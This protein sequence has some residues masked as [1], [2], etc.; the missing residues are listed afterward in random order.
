MALSKQY[1]RHTPAVKEY[2]L[3]LDILQHVLPYL[4]PSTL[5]IASLSCK[6]IR[7][8]AVK[9]LERSKKLV[10]VLETPR[11]YFLEERSF[12]EIL[13]I[14]LTELRRM[15]L[16]LDMDPTQSSS[17]LNE[18]IPTDDE[19]VA[20]M[21]H[22]HHLETVL[23]W[24]VENDVPSPSV[25]SPERVLTAKDY[26]RE[27]GIDMMNRKNNPTVV[28]VHKPRRMDV[29]DFGLVIGKLVDILNQFLDVQFLIELPN[30]RISWP[31]SQSRGWTEPGSGPIF[32][33]MDNSSYYARGGH[34]F[35]MTEKEFYDATGI[36]SAFS[37]STKSLRG[38][39]GF[40][41]FGVA[42]NGKQ[43]KRISRKGNY[44]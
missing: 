26:E 16:G 2:T 18:D 17:K 12:P 25:D 29:D 34:C 32:D 1:S 31:F 44:N 38:K 35:W 13:N 20:L 9:F 41:G 36:K 37:L 21:A 22:Q 7:N 30:G 33:I 40:D 24:L 42:S 27:F 43:R 39:R 28:V 3:T 15:G 10:Y 14:Y 5:F 19:F 8:R 6:T 23:E 4:D 11:K